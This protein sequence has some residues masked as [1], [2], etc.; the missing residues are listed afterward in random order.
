MTIAFQGPTHRQQVFAQELAPNTRLAYAK[1]WRS[2]EDFCHGRG[3]E[4]LRADAAVVSEWLLYLTY[5]IPQGRTKPLHP[6]TISLYKSGVNKA[7]EIAGFASPCDDPLVRATVKISRRDNPQ[8]TRQVAALREYQ[9]SAMLS[10]SPATVIGQRDAALIALGYAAA[11]R[12]SELIALQVKDVSFLDEETDAHA[13]VLV[14]VRQSKTDQAGHGHV[15]PVIN[16]TRIMPVTRLR[17]WL[18][19]SGISDGYL[20]RTMRRGG[21][22][23][24]NGLHTSDVPRIVK[25]YVGLIGGDSSVVSGHSLRAGF[26][27]SA[28]AHQARIDKIM[29][30][31]RHTSIDMILKYTRDANQFDAHAGE[32]FM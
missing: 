24:P 15:I 4:P 9:V 26:V 13:R 1:G 10:A 27:T 31:T 16:G 3:V 25:H 32:G 30:V 17:R 11:L 28:A 7:F 19:A 2:F 21:A 29:E 14:T 22:L 12:R 20:F 18:E 8:P 23:R 5:D 6:G